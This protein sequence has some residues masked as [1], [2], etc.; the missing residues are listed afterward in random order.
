MN[1]TNNFS[2]PTRRMFRHCKRRVLTD[3]KPQHIAVVGSRAFPNESVVETFVHALPRNAV[4]VSGAAKGV[5]TWAEEAARAAGLKTLIFHADWEGLGRRAGPLR[6]EE[7]IKHAERLVA[8]WDGD[9]RGTLNAIILAGEKGI[10][11]EIFGTN[12]ELVGLARALGRAR[13]L[14]V[15]DALE[16]GRKGGR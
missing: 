1:E 6:N 9:S 12:G 4:V 16:K 3:E 2:F 13:E 11:V 8:F 5:D 10:P 15:F 7:I 14:G